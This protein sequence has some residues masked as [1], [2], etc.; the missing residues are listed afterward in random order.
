[1]TRRFFLADSPAAFEPS[2]LMEGFVRPFACFL[3]PPSF[4][5]PATSTTLVLLRRSFLSLALRL[6]P[7]P[8][9]LPLILPSSSTALQ[10]PRRQSSPTDLPLLCIPVLPL[11]YYRTWR[12]K[13]QIS[14]SK[15]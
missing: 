14:W 2:A 9:R 7:F 8:N 15:I 12:C 5:G 3:P 13:L 1:M 4:F 11:M 10:L 6:L